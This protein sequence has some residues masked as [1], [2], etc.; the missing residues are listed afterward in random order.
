VK[1][2]SPLPFDALLSD[3]RL[4]HRVSPESQEYPL[5]VFCELAKLFTGGSTAIALAHFFMTLFSKVD[6][7]P[8]L[9]QQLEASEPRWLQTIEET[10]TTPRESL[11]PIEERAQDDSGSMQIVLAPEGT[12][13]DGDGAAAVQV[14][15]K[16]IVAQT[17]S[18]TAMA[19]QPAPAPELLNTLGEAERRAI[20]RWGEQLVF[21]M[22]QKEHPHDTVVWVNEEGETG[23]PY[24]VV[25]SD[26]T[27]KSR[28]FVEVKTTRT[29]TKRLFE[30]S[31]REWIFAYEHRGS[32]S[33]Y[34]VFGA[35]QSN[36]S[37]VRITNPWEMW[38]DGSI[39]MCISI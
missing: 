4:F 26:A 7:E 6:V 21:G 34:R 5:C 11:L 10:A 20:G 18:N 12:P 30:M 39:S 3:G 24:D 16:D 1:S 17:D 32:Y 35:F 15:V 23:T 8:L 13:A 2:S 28:H 14:N 25:I 31:S 36:V 29:T 27:G 19:S 33:I 22:L 38:K 37:V 9:G